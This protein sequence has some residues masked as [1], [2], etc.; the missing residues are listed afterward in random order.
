VDNPGIT[1]AYFT[2]RG[3]IS[4]IPVFQSY[5]DRRQASPN[6]QHTIRFETAQVEQAKFDWK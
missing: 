6:T 1:A 4:K 3:Y 2:S 5:F